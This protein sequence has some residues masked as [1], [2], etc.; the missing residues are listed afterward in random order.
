MSRTSIQGFVLAAVF[1]AAVHG[2]DGA[3]AHENPAPA[4][5]ATPFPADIGGRFA[6]IDHEGRAVTD[7][8][9]RGRFLLVFFGYAKCPGVCPVALRHMSDALDLMG[10]AGARIQP[11]LITVDPET[12][13]P[14]ALAQAIARIHPRLIGLTGTAEELAAVR[15]A[16]KVES[17]P[18]GRSW[19]GT[20]IFRHGTFVYLM[21]PDGA[22]LS[23]LPP[24]LGPERMAEILRGYLG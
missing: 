22:L 9:F 21:G 17:A 18:M 6:L 15:R 4:P 2:A 13:T 16:Y 3:K 23:V 14:E 10:E 20:Q 1:L 12:D 5:A 7:A 19:K 8:D 24:V 11:L